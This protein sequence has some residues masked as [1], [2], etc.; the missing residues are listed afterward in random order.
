MRISVLVIIFLLNMSHH[1]YTVALTFI[2][3]SEVGVGIEKNESLDPVQIDVTN[4]LFV[5]SN[6]GGDWEL[7]EPAKSERFQPPCTSE[8]SCSCGKRVWCGQFLKDDEGYFTFFQSVIKSDRTSV[9]RV[10]SGRCSK[11]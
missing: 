5:L 4:K 8:H 6:D 7:K 9:S 2:C 10:I 3:P 11:L 1:S